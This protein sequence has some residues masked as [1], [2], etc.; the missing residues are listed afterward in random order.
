MSSVTLQ[1]ILDESVLLYVEK[2]ILIIADMHIGIESELR[3]LGLHLP[4]QTALLTKQLMAMI[5]KYQPQ[6]LVL[7]GDVKHMIPSLT[8][9]ERVDVRKFLS[10][11][12][13]CGT[14]HIVP[15]NHDGN[16]KR[17]LPDAVMLHPSGGIV[18]DH[19]GFVHGHRWPSHEV[20]GCEQIVFGHSHPTIMLT[21]RRG[22]PSFESCWLKGGF[23]TD[24]LLERY[25]NAHAD[26]Q[27]LLMPA[28]NPLC[29]GIAV[30]KDML[31]GPLG[32][33]MDVA[34]AQ[35]YLRDGTALGKVKDI[36]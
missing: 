32:K 26:A 27:V 2:N 15:G 33:I 1:P 11:L 17:L 10:T 34:N 21:D 25:P 24:R 12:L 5:Q 20:M 28:Y 7:L 9:Q 22:V 8:I 35:V 23:L 16:L 3:E 13:P 6:E 18:I 14:V 29:G 31:L 30:N 19:V 36:Q 4:S